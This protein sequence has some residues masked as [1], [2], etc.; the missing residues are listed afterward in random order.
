[1]VAQSVEGIWQGLKRFEHENAVDLSSFE[2]RTMRR[3]KRTT[4]GIGKSG[5][6]RG[7]VLGHQYGSLENVLLTYRQARILIYLPSYLWILENCLQ[8]EIDTLRRMLEEG[9]VLLL[10]YETNCDIEHLDRPLSHAGLIRSYVENSWPR[11][12]LE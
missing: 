2:N 8:K 7:P 3:L 12:T 10:D 5:V 11:P 1:M 9:D 4:H 6:R